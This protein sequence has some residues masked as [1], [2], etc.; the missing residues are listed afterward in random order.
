VLTTDPAVGIYG[1][2][3]VA[4]D[5]VSARYNGPRLSIVAEYAPN[6]NRDFVT[7]GGTPVIVSKTMADS[8]YIQADYRI[9][10]NW[11]AFARMDAAFHNQSDRNGHKYADANPG[12]DPFTQFAYDFTLG[13]HWLYR[14]HWGIWGEY[15]W[16]N[17]AATILP[18]RLD[19]AGRTPDDHW[20]LG[21]LMVGYKF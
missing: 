13:G 17:G 14:E 21:M 16:I 9:T 10:S 20:F 19:N 12:G 4:T 5:V 15:H 3:D 7:V 6:L 1:S 11:G 2:F 8:G 18:G